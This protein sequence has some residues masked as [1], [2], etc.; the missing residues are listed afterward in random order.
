M[1][2]KV[3]TKRS[4][5]LFFDLIYENILDIPTKLQREKT[6]RSIKEYFVVYKDDIILF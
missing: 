3:T 4:S 6:L 2:D 5:K 1:F